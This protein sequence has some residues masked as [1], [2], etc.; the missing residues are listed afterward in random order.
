MEY[1]K[2]LD[3]QNINW[4]RNWIKFPYEIDDKIKY[5]IPDFYL[6]DTD[7]YIEIKGFERE[8]DKFKWKDFP[9]KLTILKYDELKSKGIN[10]K[11]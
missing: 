7:E 6:I 2:Y 8:N 5:Y 11:K 10:V 3:E 1:V 4:K 9:F